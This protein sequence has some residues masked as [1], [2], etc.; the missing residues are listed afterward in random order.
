MSDLASH[1][2][3]WFLLSV[4]SLTSINDGLALQVSSEDTPSFELALLPFDKVNS[5]WNQLH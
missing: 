1:V 5:A 4:L 3:P 2:P